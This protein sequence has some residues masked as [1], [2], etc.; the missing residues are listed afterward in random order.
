MKVS[1]SDRGM[2]TYRNGLGNQFIDALLVAR[3]NLDGYGDAS[4][5][6][7]LSSDSGDG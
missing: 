2:V 6:V 5:L 3:V 7:D 1:G 4:R